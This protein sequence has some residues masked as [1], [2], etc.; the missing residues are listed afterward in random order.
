M[1]KITFVILL[2]IISQFGFA[3]ESLSP[4]N[5]SQA[6]DSVIFR[7][8]DGLFAMLES[9]PI[10]SPPKL[11]VSDEKIMIE[12]LT[13]EVTF[14]EIE[15]MFTF[16]FDSDKEYFTSIFVNQPGQATN[17]TFVDLY[18]NPNFGEYIKIFE[19]ISPDFD[20]LVLSPAQIWRFCEKYRSMISFKTAPYFLTKINGVYYVVDVEP[21]PDDWSIGL[22]VLTEGCGWFSG[23]RNSF[24]VCPPLLPDLAPVAIN[25]SAGAQNEAGIL[26]VTVKNY[27]GALASTCGLLNWYNNFS[28][29]EF[30]FTSPNGVL[31]FTTDRPWPQPL[32]P[33]FNGDSITFSWEGSF[34]THGNLYLEFCVNNGGELDEGNY[35]NNCLSMVIYLRE[36][37]EKAKELDQVF[38]RPVFQEE[39][40]SSEDNLSIQ[41]SSVLNSISFNLEKSTLIKLSN[42]IGQI[43]LEKTFP[44]GKNSLDISS[45]P[46]GIYFFNGQKITKH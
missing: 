27:G 18:E 28:F 4:N 46:A 10:S 19:A 31:S 36:E 45:Y 12:S 2:T 33:L 20:K 16:S 35:N 44:A 34:N 3:Q 25:F 29:Q 21:M 17:K 5:Q 41:T 13:G 24:F 38:D 37:I 42:I 6:N 30:N 9:E 15:K 40:K 43:L 14:A 8:L 23:G 22:Q 32:L 11:I 39:R 26:S 1:K 7:P